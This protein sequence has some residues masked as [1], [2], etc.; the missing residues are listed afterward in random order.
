MIH[1]HMKEAQQV[2]ILLAELLF[3]KFRY[4]STFKD[5]RLIIFVHM[6]SAF[7]SIS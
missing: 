3:N 4:H 5:S 6:R 1:F 2:V 7:H